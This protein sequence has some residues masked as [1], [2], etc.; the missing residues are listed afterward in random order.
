MMAKNGT[1]VGGYMNKKYK[2]KIIYDTGDSF[3][4]ETDVEGEVE[5]VYWNGLDQ[6]KKGLK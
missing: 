3:H 4:N 2:I 6:A 5:E 1:S